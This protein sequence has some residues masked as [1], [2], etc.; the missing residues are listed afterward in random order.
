MDSRCVSCGQPLTEKGSVLFPC[1][2]CGKA[3]IGRCGRCRN[4]S[5]PY[6]CEECGFEG[7]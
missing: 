3:I 2:M 4:Q 1:P 5:V 6:A 7:P